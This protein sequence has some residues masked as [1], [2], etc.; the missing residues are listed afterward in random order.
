M[1]YFISFVGIPYYIEFVSNYDSYYPETV[2]YIIPINTQ[3][4]TEA[5]LNT[6]LA[7][8]SNRVTFGEV[9]VHGFNKGEWSQDLLK[10]IPPDQLTREYG[11][12]RRTFDD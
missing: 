9:R 1:I 5:A 7:P 2:K 4:T 6:I 10:L 12:T 8:F 3:R 11:G